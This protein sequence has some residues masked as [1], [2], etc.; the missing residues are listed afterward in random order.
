M[1]NYK[2]KEHFNSL[3]V[4]LFCTLMFSCSIH[5]KDSYLDTFETFVSNLEKRDKISNDEWKRISLKYDEYAVKYY[6]KYN[7]ELTNDEII[8]IGLLKVRYHKV[9]VAKKINNTIKVI[10]E[11]GEQASDILDGHIK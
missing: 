5:S 8:K 7:D 3:S 10:K 2:S 6:I 11:L 9:V 1:R 4:F